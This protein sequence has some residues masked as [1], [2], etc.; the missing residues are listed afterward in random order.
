MNIFE[1]TFAPQG[2]RATEAAHRKIELQ[3]PA[4]L[5]YLIANVS[6]AA[7]EKIDKHLP[8]DAAPEGED[9][10]RKRVE[11]LVEEYIRNTFNAAKNSMS[12]NGMDSREMDAELAKAQE[13]E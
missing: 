2:Q 8:P 12:I 7:R 1:S 9:A 5:T 4:D 13:G 11:Q 3:S 6:R 10:M